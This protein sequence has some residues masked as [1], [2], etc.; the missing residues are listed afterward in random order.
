MG[1]LAKEFPLRRRIF[2]GRHRS[3]PL[4][5]SAIARPLPSGSGL[6]AIGG[7]LFAVAN[8]CVINGNAKGC[9]VLGID[10]NFLRRFHSQTVGRLRGKTETVRGLPRFIV[11]PRLIGGKAYDAK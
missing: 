1:D 9:L 11:G 4:I 3:W 5:R 10:R 7:D 8:I 2:G 6:A